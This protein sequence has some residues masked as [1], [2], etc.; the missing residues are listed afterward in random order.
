MIDGRRVEL[1]V[2]GALIYVDA[3]HE[4]C[5]EPFLPSR[6][7]VGIRVALS[8]DPSPVSS[9]PFV[10][11]MEPFLISSM[12]HPPGPLV[13]DAENFI[14]ASDVSSQGIIAGRNFP[15]YNH[16]QVISAIGS[17]ST[18]CSVTIIRTCESSDVH[19]RSLF[20]NYLHTG[21]SSVLVRDMPDTSG[22]GRR[23]V[24]LVRPDGGAGLG[25]R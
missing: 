5:G 10:A 16:Y 19:K 2:L 8:P 22:C 23:R 11:C 1:C 18:L 14:D 9:H 6:T 12:V 15:V 3:L 17:L 25:E 24:V 13:F 7:P 4:L 20:A 21:C